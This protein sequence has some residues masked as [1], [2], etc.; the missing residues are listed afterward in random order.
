MQLDGLRR[1]D[2][3]HGREVVQVG[4]EFA[5]VTDR[6]FDLPRRCKGR[7]VQARE[8]GK[9]PRSQFI[10]I[11]LERVKLEEH[12]AIGGMEITDF[13]D[14]MRLQQAKELHH[15]FMVFDRDLLAEGNQK[16]LVAC[17]SELRIHC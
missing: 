13:V 11:E 16:R 6:N 3:V 1:R 10:M 2:P 7:L 17:G 9:Q 15:A 8:I 5:A 12:R 4:P 14:G